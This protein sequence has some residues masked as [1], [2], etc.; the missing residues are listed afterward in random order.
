MTGKKYKRLEA[1]MF[2]SRIELVNALSTMETDRAKYDRDL[3]EA[4]KRLA[5]FE[6]ALREADEVLKN[7]TLET[8]RQRRITEERE[9]SLHAHVAT[10]RQGLE[11][12][13]RECRHEKLST[14]GTVARESER[15]A[16]RERYRMTAF[17]Q[18]YVLENEFLR[19]SKIKA[20]QL[21][22]KLQERLQQSEE[23]LAKVSLASDGGPEANLT[24]AHKKAASTSGTTTGG[25]GGATPTGVAG[26]GG[27]G[28]GGGRGGSATPS[29]TSRKKHRTDADDSPVLTQ[30]ELA[31]RR[32]KERLEGGSGPP[33]SGDEKSCRG[34][35]RGGGGGRVTAATV[36]ARR[37]LRSARG[38]AAELSSLLSSTE[39]ERDSLASLLV[40]AERRMERMAVGQ[41]EAALHMAW[42]N[43]SARQTPPQQQQQQTPRQQ[44]RQQQKQQ[45]QQKQQQ[46]Q[47]QAIALKNG[48]GSVTSETGT[49]DSIALSQ[50]E[51][52]PSRSSSATTSAAL[53]LHQPAPSTNHPPLALPTT[54]SSASHPVKGV[55]ISQEGRVAAIETIQ[56]RCRVRDL[57]ALL[58]A[59]EVGA[60]EIQ[61]ENRR[62]KNRRQS[63]SGAWGSSLLPWEEPCGVPSTE[64]RTRQ[65]GAH[66]AGERAD[67]GDRGGYSQDPQ[68]SSGG[69]VS[70]GCNASEFGFENTAVNRGN[71]GFQ[72]VGAESLSL[73]LLSASAAEKHDSSSRKRTRT[74]G[75]FAGTGQ[76]PLDG[77]YPGASLEGQSRPNSPLLRQEGEL[78]VLS[79]STLSQQREQQNDQ[80][81]EQ[82]NEQQFERQ[83]QR[84]G[85]YEDDDS[86]D[87]VTGQQQ[88]AWVLGLPA[89]TTTSYELLAGVMHLVAERGAAS[90]DAATLE[91][92]LA[93]MD[94]QS[95]S[96]TRLA[97]TNA[98]AV[99]AAATQMC[100]DDQYI[101]GDGS[102]GGGGGVGGGGGGGGG[103][104][105]A[106]RG[107]GGCSRV[108]THSNGG[109][110]GGGSGSGSG[111]RRLGG[112]MNSKGG[113]G[114]NGAA[115]SQNDNNHNVSGEVTGA[116]TVAQSEAFRERA[117]TGRR[118]RSAEGFEPR[119]VE[120]KPEPGGA[121]AG[122]TTALAGMTVAGVVA[123][124]AAA[125]VGEASPPAVALAEVAA[126][127]A[128]AAG[129]TNEQSND[130]L[131]RASFQRTLQGRVVTV[132][133]F[134]TKVLT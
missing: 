71:V 14:W 97:T 104:G 46:L 94:A 99:A 133:I 78:S 103:G 55:T 132:D 49:R 3:G 40:L 102:G 79:M 17:L 98:A 67:N 65:S 36:T 77:C 20:E 68:S 9:A 1:D 124:A 113:G 53:K 54:T 5:D 15:A 11:Q 96:L 81:N 87:V 33:A 41:E 12:S 111:S 39:N 64:D 23:K 105:A 48:G 84:R 25:R 108:G 129:S 29:P 127:E 134:C 74:A 32:L 61:K 27:G 107:G 45:H 34:T 26:G 88:L 130:E 106:A 47:Q 76:P 92:Q 7:L 86:V 43:A 131:A 82:Q 122:L 58:N 56:L 21:A 50:A 85:V 73:P 90:T 66:P 100:R 31:V 112:R 57:E 128:G 72:N 126:E 123:A 59:T 2:R 80:Q 114:G 110:S 38:L 125:A 4:K 101:S 75:L 91:A 13:V 120:D 18:R 63:S 10:L 22:E 89:A 24:I 121:A 44:R 51:E 8:K 69:G 37:E 83:Q 115:W 93:E 119:A 62:L 109:G 95:L 117:A 116:Q 30:A 60:R 52:E 70:G 42:G 19:A 118:S 28:G 16:G 6:A 35:D